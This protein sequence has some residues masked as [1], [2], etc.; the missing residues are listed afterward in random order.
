M[1]S[2]SAALAAAVLL[3]GTAQA[4]TVVLVRHAEKAAEPAA[5]PGLTPG[6][7]ARA[8]AL[9]AALKDARVT[10][11]LTSPLQR[12]IRTAAPLAAAARV[13]SRAVPMAGGTEAH[14]AAVAAF[15]RAAPQDATVVVVGHSNTIPLIAQALGHAAAEPIADCR[16]DGMLVLRLGAEGSAAVN[17]RY[18]APGAC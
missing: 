4:Q 8:A 14:V 12:T 5:D 16:Y 17:A 2:L 15:A 1:K 13:E 9:V 3:A 7:E 18:G 6:G 11:V 10:A